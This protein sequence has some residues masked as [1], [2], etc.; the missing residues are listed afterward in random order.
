MKKIRIS[1]T[2]V[3][4]LIFM[5]LVMPVAEAGIQTLTYCGV[6]FGRDVPMNTTAFTYELK[7]ALGY[8]VNNSSY[9]SGSNVEFPNAAGGV[10][11]SPHSHLLGSSDNVS[12]FEIYY[13]TS[14]IKGQLLIFMGKGGGG[15][16]NFTNPN[17]HLPQFTEA[18]GSS[19][20]IHI[21][22]VRDAN[23]RLTVFFNGVGP[24][25]SGSSSGALTSATYMTDNFIYS[26]SR[27]FGTG[28][29]YTTDV[30]PKQYISNI[31]LV[32]GAALYDATATTISVP[33]TADL[34]LNAASGTTQ[35]LLNSLS[36][37][38]IVT[39]SAVPTQVNASLYAFSSGTAQNLAA[40]I[41]AGQSCDVNT[42]AAS[43]IGGDGVYNLYFADG[44]TA[45]DSGTLPARQYYDSTASPLVPVT[46]P[47][48]TMT[49][50]GYA[51]AGWNTAANGTGTTYLAGSSYSPTGN[52]TLY[53]KWVAAYA[54]T[55][56]ANGGTGTVPTQAA[57]ASGGTFIVAANTLTK[58]SSLFNGWYD[59]LATYA[60]GSTYTM[61]SAAKTLTATWTTG[62]KA[63]Y[64]ANSATTGTVPTTQ[65]YAS[66][67]GTPLTISSN[68]GNLARTGYTFAGWATASNGTGTNY[69]EGQ[70][71]V[72]LSADVTLYAKWTGITY[73]ATYDAN[74]ATSGTVPAVQ[75][76]TTGGTALTLPGNSGTLARSGYTFAGWATAADGSGTSYTAAQTNVT[77]TADRT[78]YAKWTANSNVV[79]YNS[80]LGT[81]VGNGSFTTGSTLTLPAAPTRTGYTFAGWFTASTGGSALVSG[82]S[83]TETA[84][85][86]IYAQWTANTYTVTYNA[87]SSTSG[88]APGS[89]SY[90]SGGTTLTL[91]NNSGTLARTGY[92]FAGW[93]TLANGS[94][95]NYASGASLQTFTADTTLYAKWT[96]NIYTA[97]YNSNSSTSGTV[98]SVQTYTTG[99]SAIT[100]A[101]NTGTL[102]RTGYTF[103]GWNTAADGTGTSY[104]VSQASVTLS[105]DTTLYAK[106]TANTYT[107]TYNANTST[108][109]TAPSSQSYTSGSSTLTLDNN[110]GTLAR[111]G[112]TFDGWNTL[113]NGT[114]TNYA[115]GATA[116]IFTANTTLYAKWSGIT[117][118]ATYDENN[119]TSGTVPTLQS[120]TTG[121]TALTLRG[122]IGT[123]A[124]AGYAFA[125]WNTAAD[126]SGTSYTAA[127]ASVTLTADRTLY[128]KWTANSNVVT[129]NSQLGTT[130]SN[131]SFI[132]G[133]TLTLPAAPTRTGY[134]FAGWF[135]ADTGGT[136]LVSGYSPTET[137]AITIYAQWTANTYTVTYDDNGSTSGAAPGSQS[138]TSGG[139]TLNLATNSGALA[140]VGYTFSGWNTAV[141]G[142][143]TSYPSGATSRTFTADTILYARWNSGTFNANYD[144]NSAT[145]GTVPT[146]Q[147]Y[148]SGGTALT[149]ANNL[150]TLARTGYT[151][152][153]WNTAADGTGTSYTVS[154]ASVTLIDDV[155]LYA[156]WNGISYTVTY[157]ANSASSGT[158]PSSQSY[159]SGGTAITLA[160]NSGTLA[161]IG[162][163]FGGWNTEADGTGTSYTVSQ[164]NVIL[165]IDLTLYA[166]WNGL[167][168]T[169]TY[170]A[171]GA[172]SG[173]VPSSQSYTSGAIGLTLATNTG[174]LVRIGYTFVGWNTLDDGTGTSYSVSQA[175][176][177]ITES[178]TL[179]A[180]W[181]AKATRSLTFAVLT[182]SINIGDTVTATA[183]LSV[184]SGVITYSAGISTACIVDADSGLVT[185]TNGV[186]TCSISGSTP[187]D[188][189]Y[190]A[191]T[192]L[193]PVVITVG[194]NT[195]AIPVITNVAA[196]ANTMQ[197][198]VTQS[199]LNTNGINN[200]KYSIDG[201]TYIPIGSIAS[202]LSITGLT[203]GIYSVR[204]KAVNPTGESAPSTALTVIV[205]AGPSV[206]VNVPSAAPARVNT[207]PSAAEIEAAK[208]AAVDKALAEKA[209]AD[210]L[211][212]D[213]AAA[214]KAL[215]DKLAAEKAA[216]EKVLADKLAA[217][218]A[219]A[220]K[221]LA[222]KLAAEKVI[223]DKAAADKAA[224][225]KTLVD[226]LAAEKAAA[227][228]LAAEKLAAEKLATEKL[229]AEK[230]AADKLVAEK[231]AAEKL[232]AEKLAAQQ[233]LAD[234]LAAEK[235][236]AEKLA[237]C[238]LGKNS[239]LVT[240]QS[241]TMRI[242]S[243]ICFIPELL[244]PI[245][246]DLAEINKVISLIK[247][248]KIKSI[249]LL[250]FADEKLGV[251][252]KSVAKAR[253][254][255]VSGIIQ[256]ALPNLK[257]DYKLY[258]S[259]AK[260]NIVSQGRVVITAN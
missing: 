244:K 26:S 185:V 257:I 63:T 57:V 147:S 20:Y 61:G 194:F 259:S 167:S 53:T 115:S 59:G 139:T 197:L 148:T 124:R 177:T 245:N 49:K 161:R 35:V 14:Y 2:I 215:A 31:R 202:P 30:N 164:L 15:Q 32:T 171:N 254:I 137:A 235:A 201:T 70:T 76:Y 128:A 255:V 68:T 24:T 113:A 83:P 62:Y 18:Q 206:T 146:S 75:S 175:N 4:T 95:T 112:Y 106:W 132:T 159:T 166:K 108:S 111:T 10:L 127:Q 243:Q 126:G 66:P 152:A 38:G 51:F 79:T 250:S 116:Q 19:S 105:A 23:R 121:G 189:I 13:N 233:V 136:A 99:G 86:T 142:S 256:S 249:T 217:E 55:Y 43:Y 160:T 218:K 102:A 212:A 207:G 223:A 154:Q 100:L 80:Q 225:E 91:D 162:Y 93:N 204:L 174:T 94:G 156:K 50:A 143:G 153:G 231:L 25:Q 114:G 9:T 37:S 74:N 60:A 34:R 179:F 222:D 129:Y 3:L 40:Q 209:A 220:E 188:L 88:A 253:A 98:P 236:A 251:D 155:T 39:N 101:A 110:S 211:A 1:I 29:V 183:A 134:T 240:A 133:L 234:K 178:T 16:Y 48:N 42:P 21:A 118:T 135:A 65:E 73:T 213:K 176:V 47:A 216:A 46:V 78:L 44:T 89:Q 170:S 239:T 71:G 252:F 36:P 165:T 140:R 208:K 184:G 158:I 54:V 224:A 12:G 5:N 260:K 190:V 120:Y 149:L 52:S 131:G 221:V 11:L 6:S 191:L 130:V 138:Y 33:S 230:L 242:Y 193:A 232:L 181:S 92:S 173:T 258:G 151:F 168:Y 72:T 241:K 198:T 45:S 219:A 141:N 41:A 247:S 64:N 67:S 104:T 238:I 7:Y 229:V 172:T 150:G 109:G 227:E 196:S 119:A 28:V 200:Y 56:A 8:D 97:T 163:T 182:Y 210:K 248:K 77:L 84:A 145:S 27:Y 117:Y 96:G 195:P 81:A 122:N 186:G 214:E 103:A 58:A 87:N 226:K 237:A 192:S 246:K 187:E 17:W 123:L 169:A 22:V 107:V 90:T 157:N 205:I 82:Y 203:P 69:T 125:G 85:I 228:K 199:D 180:K 144:A